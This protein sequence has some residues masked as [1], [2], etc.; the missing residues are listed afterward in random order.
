MAVDTGHTRELAKY[1]SGLAFQTIPDAAV[2]DC[3]KLILD[4]LGI[5]VRGSRTRHGEI[6][7]RFIHELG[8]RPESTVVGYGYRTSCLNA[9][10]ANGIMAHAIDFDDDYQPGMIHVGCSVIPAALAVAES[11]K[12]SGKELIC[13]I[14]AGYDVSSRVAASVAPVHHTPLGFHPTGTANCFG[15]AAA[16]GVLLKLSQDELLNA[17]GIAGDQASGLRQYHYDGSMI[18]HFHAGKAAQNGI[19]AALLAK[20]GFTGSPQILEGEWGFCK[21]LSYNNYKL[22][23]LTS[24][25]GEEFAITRTSIKPYPCCRATHPSIDAAL[26]LQ[27]EYGFDAEQIERIVL[28]VYDATFRSNNKPSP[29][30]GLQAI[31]SQQYCVASALI[32][33]TVS[34]DDFS[35]EKIWDRR[36]RNLMS[37]IEVVEDA[38]LTQSFTE[39][40]NRRPIT[41]EIVMRDGRRF[42]QSIEYPLGSP[43]NP[44]SLSQVSQK[45]CALASSVLDKIKVEKAVSSV[46]SLEHI[47]DIRGLVT[48]LY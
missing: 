26:S 33:G 35:P 5:A 16:A 10:F 19:L 31:L 9:A 46:M 6:A 23:E 34:V 32:R 30:T 29:D 47:K 41:L 12:S 24:G 18:K 36:V 48:L 17:L 27:H 42:T 14:V 8:G 3:K 43:E 44:M 39:N 15:A 45:F 4:T 38:R 1:V 11:Q 13:V 7:A 37:K 40:R 25:L 2:Q 20:R 28:R 22:E 21:V